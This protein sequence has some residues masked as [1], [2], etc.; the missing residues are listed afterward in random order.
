M[1]KSYFLACVVLLATC[2]TSFAEWRDHPE[3]PDWCQRGKVHWT[4]GFT[5]MDLA[6]VNMLIELDQNLKQSGSFQLE[7]ALRDAP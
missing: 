7:E 1:M 6:R 4:H 5:K 3:L 2:T